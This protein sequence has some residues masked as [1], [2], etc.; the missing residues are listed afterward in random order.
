MFADAP[1]GDKL[2]PSVAP[3]SNPKYNKIGF[4]PSV[5]DIEATTGNIVA[6]YGMLSMKADISTLAQTINV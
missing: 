4:M 1:I 2:P 6:T 3:V 5:A